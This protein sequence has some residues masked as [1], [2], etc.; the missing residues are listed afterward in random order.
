MSTQAFRERTQSYLKSKEFRKPF[1]SDQ[2]MI[3]K[4][5][6]HSVSLFFDGETH[7]LRSEEHRAKYLEF[8]LRGTAAIG[9]TFSDGIPLAPSQ[10]NPFLVASA[11]DFDFII[12]HRILKRI[13]IS[14]ARN[15]RPLFRQMNIKI[16][17]HHLMQNRLI[18][19]HVLRN[20]ELWK[21]L[22]S[23]QI[24]VMNLGPI[25]QL[26]DPLWWGLLRS[27][28]HWE[29]KHF[30]FAL[31]KGIW[32]MAK[33]QILFSIN[34]EG[35][36]PCVIVGSQFMCYI[37]YYSGKYDYNPFV[38]EHVVWSE[39]PELMRQQVMS[40][41]RI[42]EIDWLP[43][44]LDNNE[45]LRPMEFIKK[46]MRVERMMERECSW[47]PCAHFK[48]QKKNG[49]DMKP[50]FKCGGCKLIRYCCRRH[51]KKHWKFVH[52][53]QCRAVS[54]IQRGSCSP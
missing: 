45:V 6:K 23:A 32:T 10:D 19:R 29:D 37:V 9:F 1:L 30:A 13:L 27:M 26:E 17:T 40:G 52:S 34:I 43:N 2:E 48:P 35:I 16:I 47:P 28:K 18:V 8:M 25:Q 51:Q 24:A 33:S 5:L 31:N 7:D 49:E 53:Q 36:C 20:T 46:R 11:V 44:T 14:I 39:L 22:I 54:I 21:P 12:R 41:K 3:Q 42:V 38:Y 4:P 50:S 15:P